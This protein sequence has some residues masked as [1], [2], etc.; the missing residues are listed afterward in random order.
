[1]SSSFAMLAG[2]DKTSSP[3]SSSCFAASS[4]FSGRRAETVSP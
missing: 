1:M 4:S 3:S 2:T